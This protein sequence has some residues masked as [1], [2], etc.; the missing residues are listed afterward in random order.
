N[1][2]RDRLDACGDEGMLAVSSIGPATGRDTATRPA[3]AWRPKLRWNPMLAET[4]RRH[5]ESMATENFFDH[6]DRQGRTVGARARAVGYR[7]RVVGENL[8]AGHPSIEEAIRG[9]LMSASHC[10]NLIDARFTEFGIARVQSRDANDRY[11][12]YWT[13]VLGVQ[14]GAQ[15]A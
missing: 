11:G 12:A 7:Y 13:L 1:N 15:V 5:S 10:R 14:Q 3:V 2:I 8:A 9:W 4:A 6:V